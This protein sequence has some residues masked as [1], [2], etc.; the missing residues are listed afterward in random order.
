VIHD[1]LH[2]FQ[3][4]VVFC[5]LQPGIFRDILEILCELPESSTLTMMKE[6]SLSP[7]DDFSATLSQIAHKSP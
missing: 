4:G 7:F 2:R 5:D 1:E 3:H 6:T